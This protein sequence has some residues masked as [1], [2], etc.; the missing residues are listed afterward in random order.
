AG[1]KFGIEVHF[2]ARGMRGERF[3]TEVETALY[4]V[5]QEAMANVVRHARASRADVLLQLRDDRVMVMVEDNGVGFEP[6][7][8]RRRGD[9]VGLLGLEERAEA[10]GGTLTVESAPGAGATIVVEVPIADPHPDR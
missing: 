2:K 6:E 9:H 8:V 10:L 7:Q 3:S 4:R 5:V 1:S